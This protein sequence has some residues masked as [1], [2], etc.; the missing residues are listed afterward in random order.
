MW[1]QNHITSLII[2]PYLNIVTDLVNKLHDGDFIVPV[3]SYLQQ[4]NHSFLGHLEKNFKLRI[5]H[6]W[7][8][9]QQLHQALLISLATKLNLWKFDG[10]AQKV[11]LFSWFFTDLVKV[12]FTGII[13]LEFPFCLRERGP[14]S[15]GW[16]LAKIS[17]FL[18][19]L[20][21]IKADLREL[22]IK[23]FKCLAIKDVA[24]RIL[25]QWLI[26]QKWWFYIHLPRLPDI[27]LCI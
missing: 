11:F 13:F 20:Y 10:H 27:F 3:K 24:S 23:T 18:K 2:A 5:N 26:K 21:S 17:E 22:R 12:A 15:I 25:Y 8:G 1:R 14:W 9:V 16:S 6:S 4:K 7:L 19:F